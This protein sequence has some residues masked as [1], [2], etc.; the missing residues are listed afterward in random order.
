M[1][2]GTA[3]VYDSFGDSLVIEV[4]DLFTEKTI[5]FG[6]WPLEIILVHSPRVEQQQTAIGL[7]LVGCESTLFGAYISTAWGRHST[8]KKFTSLQMC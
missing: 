1:R 3:S 8:S 7:R 6:L 2:R 4:R 5:I